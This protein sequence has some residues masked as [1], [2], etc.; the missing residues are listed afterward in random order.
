[1]GKRKSAPEVNAGSMADIAFLLLIFFLVTTT[2]ETDVG[3]DRM[4]PREDGDYI[5]YEQ[6][7][8]LSIL[9][10]VDGALLVNDEP[11]TPELLLK[12]VIDFIDNGGAQTGEAFCDYCQGERRTNLSDNPSKAVLVLGTQRETSYGA[13]IAVQN[14]LVAAYNVLRNREANRL[15][16][17]SYIKMDAIYRNP[18]TDRTTKELLNNR[19]RVIQKMYPMNISEAQLKK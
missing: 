17:T 15:F 14:E 6:R 5:E 18:Q 9:I 7:N 10:G 16:K 1:M 3:L 11:I 13:Y 2:I 19:I 4:L 12:T 8:I